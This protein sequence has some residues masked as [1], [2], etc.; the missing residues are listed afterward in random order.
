MRRLLLVLFASCVALAVAPGV[1]SAH[2]SLDSSTPADGAALDIAPSQVVW[3]FANPVPLETLTVTLTDPNN[4]RSELPGSAHG[5]AGT[6]EV[7]TPLPP[8]GSGPY[9]VRWRLVGADGH[10]ISDSISFTIAAAPTTTAATTSAGATSP[11]PPT[12]IAPTL[13]NTTVGPGGGDDVWAFPSPLRWAVRALGYVAIMIAAG[14]VLVERLINDRRG[15]SSRRW[16]GPALL[17]VGATAAAQLLVIASDITGRAPWSAIGDVGRALETIAGASLAVRILLALVGC[18]LLVKSPPRTE[19]VR[20]SV[21]VLLAIGLLATWSFAGHSRSMRWPALGV[22]VD[23][24]HHG[25]AA[26]WIGGL[27]LVGA[28][29][30]RHVATDDMPRLMQRFSAT[31]RTAVLVIVATGAIQALRLVGN[32]TNLFRAQHGWLLTAKLVVLVVMLVAADQN[33]RRVELGV[34]NKSNG[35]QA[36]V[37]A[38]R[39]MLLVEVATGLVIV[40]ITAALVVSAPATS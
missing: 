32:P 28:L 15:R 37:A 24:V 1:A 5:P 14:T 11:T 29:V 17:V 31:A 13:P 3:S 20:R 7:V 8:L 10:P 34:R 40:G 4:V 9:S 30:F 18:L 25:A 12:T 6:T 38:L 36:D 22:P 35:I 23:V 2:N 16:L 39:K 33:R 21:L 19:E 26:A 27:V